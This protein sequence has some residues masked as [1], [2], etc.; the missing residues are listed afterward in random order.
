MCVCVCVCAHVCV[1]HT[2]KC[3]FVRMYICVCV[4]VSACVLALWRVSIQA[5]ARAAMPYVLHTDLFPAPALTQHL[6]VEGGDGGRA[7]MTY[8]CIY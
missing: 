7:A 4:Y 1:I 3:A 6:E 2:C 5:Y 8:V